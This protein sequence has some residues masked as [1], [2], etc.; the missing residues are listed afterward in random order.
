MTLLG[1]NKL[2]DIMNTEDK[3]LKYSKNA[4]FH[5]INFLAFPVHSS[6]H[7]EWFPR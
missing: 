6:E 1:C 5:T 2:N 3:G 7:I 4:T